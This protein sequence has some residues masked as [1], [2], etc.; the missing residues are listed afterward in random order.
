MITR[1]PGQRPDLVTDALVHRGLV[2]PAHSAAARDVLAGG[3]ATAAPRTDA[4][5]SGPDAELVGAGPD[6]EDDF[7]HGESGQDAGS[8]V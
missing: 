8:I 1:E 4:E 6:V 5:R 2:L 7:V 3:R